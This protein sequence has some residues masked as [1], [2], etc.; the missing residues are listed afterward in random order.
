MKNKLTLILIIMAFAI[1]YYTGKYQNL[2]ETINDDLSDLALV[3]NNPQIEKQRS[4]EANELLSTTTAPTTASLAPLPSSSDG[5]G[6]LNTTLTST[7]KTLSSFD[8]TYD[9]T[10]QPG[11]Q[12]P[13]ETIDSEQNDFPLAQQEL[14]EWQTQHKENLKQRM[15]EALG[16]AAD[17]MFE[18]VTSNSPFLLDTTAT[19]PLEDD[20]SW[21][22]NAE[23]AITDFIRNHA[24]DPSLEILQVV[25]IQKK[26]EITVRGAEQPAA[27]ALYAQITS[28]K[29]FNLQQASTP[30][31]FNNDDGSF[32]LYVVLS[33]N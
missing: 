7:E 14:K 2:T 1:G 29:P 31:I 20:L 28:K 17:F 25:C 10:A 3:P 26:C 24:T 13:L 21:R 32:W 19:A 30:T 18:Q 6:T 9:E 22:Y 4:E 15:Q 27:F 23:Q 12:A 8:A 11:Q 33:F 5:M 16:E